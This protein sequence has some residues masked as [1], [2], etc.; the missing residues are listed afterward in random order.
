VLAFSST[1]QATLIGDTVTCSISTFV[2][3]CSTPT[4]VVAPA[5]EFILSVAARPQFLVDIG[6]SSIAVTLFSGGFSLSQSGAV[7][8]LG[9]LDDSAGDIVG[10]ANFI[11]TGTTGIDA[12]DVAFTAHTA[13]L[14]LDESAWTNGNEAVARFDLIV[15]S[16]AA[17]VDE[18]GSVATIGIALAALGLSRRRKRHIRHTP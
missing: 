18:P 4:A 13:T 8:Q 17:A 16:A 7:L 9:S 6:A 12:S 14:N 15:R 2:L 5:P 10:I 1:A 11:T 3:D